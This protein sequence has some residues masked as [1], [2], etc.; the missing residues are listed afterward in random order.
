[1]EVYEAGPRLGGLL[2][3]AIADYRLPADILDWDIQ[4]VLDMGVNAHTGKTL[5]IDFTVNTLLD[6]GFHAVFTALGGWDSRLARNAGRSAKSPIPGVFLL[7]DFVKSHY[8][9]SGDDDA[10]PIA[11]PSHA[12]IFGGGRLALTAA[13]LC[14]ENGADQ[15]TVLY[16]ESE[17]DID[18]DPEKV[19]ELRTKGA[20]I[21]FGVAVNR[22]F[23]E[24]DK[25][26]E[27]EYVELAGGT[28]KKLPAGML[29]VASGRFPELVF[30]RPP[31]AV[32]E[33]GDAASPEALP[34]TV[35]QWIGVYTYKHP[36]HIHERGWL[37]NGDVPS[38]YSGA[39]KAIGGG[40]RAAATVHKIINNIPLSLPD[41]V[42]NSRAVIQNVYQ[43]EQVAASPRTIMPQATPRELAAKV[44]IEKGFSKEMA[45]TESR[46]CL[47]CGLICY[48][49]SAPYAVEHPVSAQEAAPVH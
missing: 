35:S 22:I 40:R 21:I 1:V 48:E 24:Q 4:G 25:L 29:V 13:D 41:N 39:I 37:S 15:V 3:S 19:A 32:G 30:S 44:E 20:Q 31:A 33:N 7:M 5:G 47:Q 28:L 38:D 26:D 12:A 43:L 49:H 11:C 9:A 27:I 23:G 8:S 42:V 10:T 14:L 6:D 18:L 2:R 46:R 34:G 45:N 16:R 36:E 17:N